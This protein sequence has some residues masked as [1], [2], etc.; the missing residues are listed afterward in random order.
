MSRSPSPLSKHRSDVDTPVVAFGGTGALGLITVKHAVQQQRYTASLVSRTGRCPSIDELTS[1][2]PPIRLLSADVTTSAALTNI[3][4]LGMLDVPQAISLLANGILRDAAVG[5]TSFGLAR[6]VIA[7]KCPVTDMMSRAITATAQNTTIYFSSIASFLGS[8]GQI[9]YS[10]ANSYLDYS[11]MA[12]T[13]AGVPSCSL[14]WGPWSG[15]GMASKYTTK[16]R[17]LRIGIGTIS[18]QEGASI[19][20]TLLQNICRGSFFP[21]VNVQNMHSSSRLGEVCAGNATV[22]WGCD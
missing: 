2:Y 21:L 12:W 20:V 10:A 13:D 9:A 3:F 6:E 7:A 16:S 19:C 22:S 4:K 14:Q 5:T 18:P 1:V 17:L 11:A 15:I 8:A